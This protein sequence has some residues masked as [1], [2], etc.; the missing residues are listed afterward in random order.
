M[1]AFNARRFV[2][3]CAVLATATVLTTFTTRAGAQDSPGTH[4]AD[5]IIID[6]GTAP[7]PLGK[8]TLTVASLRHEADAFV[9]SYE[10]Q[11]SPLSIASEKGNLSVGLSEEE[12]RTLREKRAVSFHGDATNTSGKHRVIDGR[13]TPTGADHGDITLKIISERGKLVFHTTYRFAGN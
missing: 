7:V 4:A 6:P 8:A 13:A 11:V 9:G 10:V 3:L 12:I 5:K 2:V 1:K